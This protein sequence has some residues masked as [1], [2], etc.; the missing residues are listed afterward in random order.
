MNFQEHVLLFKGL[1]L[2]TRRLKGA[3]VVW[4]T[5]SMKGYHV[6]GKFCHVV[7]QINKYRVQPIV[8]RKHSYNAQN[9]LN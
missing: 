3:P 5:I 7:A 8:S 2:W 6:C 1:D 4:K 9:N